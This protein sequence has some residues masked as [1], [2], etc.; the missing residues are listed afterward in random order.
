[1]TDR[2]DAY[3]DNISGNNRDIPPGSG[4]DNQVNNGQMYSNQMNNNRMYDNR[5][6]YGYPVPPRPVQPVRGERGSGKGLFFGGLIT[7]IAGA[8]M[9]FAICY[10]GLYIQK[11]MEA[12]R[13]PDEQFQFK[14]GSAI[15]ESVLT[16]LQNLES[17][18][19]K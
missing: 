7:G 15:D 6:G 18:V 1:M 13:Q 19:N 2:N 11:L 5:P 12:P 8:L 17:T 3:F 16:K 14:E 4:S 9:I 10:L